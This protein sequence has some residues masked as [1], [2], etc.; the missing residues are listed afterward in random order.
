VTRNCW[1]FPHTHTATTTQNDCEFC[2]GVALLFCSFPDSD[3]V[4]IKKEEEEGLRHGVVV[5][6][7]SLSNSRSLARP[8]NEGEKTASGCPRSFII[9]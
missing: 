2:C 3:F 6:V 8:F 1:P 5:L 4:T 7:V 9:I